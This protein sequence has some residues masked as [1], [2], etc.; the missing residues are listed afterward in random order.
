MHSIFFANKRVVQETAFR[1][2]AASVSYATKELIED[3]TKELIAPKILILGLGEIGED[4]C[5]NLV[6]NSNNVVIAN[7][8]VEKAIS[9]AEE[10]NFISIDFNLAINNLQDFDVIVSSVAHNEP[11]ITKNLISKLDIL[12]PKFFIDLSV[13]RSIETSIEDV[14]GA[15]LYNIDN[16]KSKTSEALKKRI[17]SIPAVENI[18]SES[19][20]EFED[21]SKE[22]LV[23]PTIKKLK[24]ALESIRLE[25]I[26]RH[27]KDADSAESKM[28]ETVTK[29]M[30]Q[31]IMKL[32]V[33]Q[34]KAACKRG[35]AETLIDVLNNLFDL[36]KE[37]ELKK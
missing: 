26:K 35:E 11:I 33:L 8:T 14:P 25:E 4:V 10:C 21:W 3:I 13:P 36:E 23:S 19:L 29:S 12:S 37:N 16:I 32:P 9:L 2:G 1:D 22:M 34:L 6:G 24:S 7:R 20:I 5:R 28:I 31:K 27:L 17:E 18:I 30:M 15:L